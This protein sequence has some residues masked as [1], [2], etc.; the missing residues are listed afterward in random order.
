MLVSIFFQRV[1]PPRRFQNKSLCGS[2]NSI[3]GP[4][5]SC[6]SFSFQLDFECTNNG[7]EYEALIIGL[8]ILLELNVTIVDILGDSQLVLKYI[9][10]EYKCTNPQF[11]TYLV[12]TQNLLQEFID[13]IWGYI[14][15]EE[16]FAGNEM[17]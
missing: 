8:E 5:R 10:G 7:A 2:W 16:N 17:A 12:A 11:A 14:P 6:S 15:R 13:A 9:V 4:R 3:G 1:Y